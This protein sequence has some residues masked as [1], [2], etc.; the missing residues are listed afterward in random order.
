VVADLAGLPVANSSLLD[1]ATAAA[2]AMTLARRASKSKSPRFLVDA[3]VFPQTLAV[4]QT[5]AEPLG[6]ELALAD[7]SADAL[8]ASRWARS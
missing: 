8:P 6:I 4:L 2:E 3:D 1:E 5:R 7:L